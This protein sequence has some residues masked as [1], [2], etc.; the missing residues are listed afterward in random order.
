MGLFGS[1]IEVK[2]VFK[3]EFKFGFELKLVLGFGFE[4]GLQLRNQ[5]GP[6]PW[7]VEVVAP[8]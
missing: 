3:I 5:S 6:I 7:P 8:S 4:F 1:G 2:F